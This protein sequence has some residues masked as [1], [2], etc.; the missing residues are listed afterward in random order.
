MVKRPEDAKVE[1]ALIMQIFPRKDVYHI[2]L[3]A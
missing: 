3:D 2:D 1:A